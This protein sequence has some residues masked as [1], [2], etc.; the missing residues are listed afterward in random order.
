MAPSAASDAKEQG[1]C[2]LSSKASCSYEGWLRKRALYNRMH[3]Q[4]R[5]FRLFEHA[6]QWSRKSNLSPT[7]EWPLAS[8]NSVRIDQHNVKGRHVLRL[9]T[10][11]PNAD[12]VVLHA[13]TSYE[14]KQWLTAISQVLHGNS[15]DPNIPVTPSSLLPTLEH[16]IVV[17]DFSRNNGTSSSRS[18]LCAVD[19]V[20]VDGSVTNLTLG[21]SDTVLKIK[22]SMQK[23]K[24]YTYTNIYISLSEQYKR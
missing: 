14:A 1:K 18:T 10:C 16:K 21:W 6:L 8:F 3:W 7:K 2:K 11:D 19:V 12:D 23:Q 15:L 5:Y 9:S 24:G 4:W 22:A 13:D 17:G 20:G